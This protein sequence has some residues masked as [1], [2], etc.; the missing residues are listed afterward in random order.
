M[1]LH[2]PYGMC[3]RFL[4]VAKTTHSLSQYVQRPYPC[5]QS[6]SLGDALSPTVTVVRGRRP[7][8]VGEGAIKC[9]VAPQCHPS[10]NSAVSRELSLILFYERY[11]LIIYFVF[12][13]KRWKKLFTKVLGFGTLEQLL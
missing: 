6:T 1:H 12:R 2:T 3:T 5:E 8:K 9:A 11:D 13:E 7:L 4:T 10:R